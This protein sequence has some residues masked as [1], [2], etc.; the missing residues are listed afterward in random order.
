M[1]FKQKNIKRLFHTHKS[2]SNKENEFD[3][4]LWEEIDFYM[5]YK[6]LRL[7]INKI[8]LAF[9]NEIKKK[10]DHNILHASIRKAN[11]EDLES[12][13]YM[14][15]SSWLTSNTPFSKITLE[16]L[17]NLYHSPGI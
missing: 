4:S 9:E 11:E 3:E 6:L 15:N 1:N 5:V 13:V 7:P 17:T 10:I 2:A 8:T 14:Y 12:L 16:S